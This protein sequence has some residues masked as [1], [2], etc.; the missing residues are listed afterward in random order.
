[1]DRIVTGATRPYRSEL[2]EAQ[3]EGTRARIL[4]AAMRVISTGIAGLS[5]PAVAREA[6]VSVPTVYR[7]FPTKREL[8]AAV[9]PHAARRTGLDTIPDPRSVD[10]LRPMIRAV[11]DRLDALDDLSRAAMASPGASE[12]RRAT[13]PSRIARIRR[14]ADSIEP[15][16]R[17]ADRD[18]ITRLLVVLTASAS[19]RMWRD[20]LEL[21]ADEV[22]DDIDWIL[23]AAIA[24]ASETRKP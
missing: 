12:V 8:L 22:A 21:S 13:M 19:L 10:E 2:R 9:Y 5:V 4:D 7:H 23:R 18:R 3:A 20:H 16:L 17:K 11:I 15:K 14:V 6:G 1:M 24:A